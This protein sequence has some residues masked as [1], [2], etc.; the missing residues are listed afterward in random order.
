M[1]P[2]TASLQFA[3]RRGCPNESKTSLSSVGSASGCKCKPLHY[4]LPADE[5]YLYLFKTA[6]VT[7]ALTSE[8]CGLDWDNVDLLAGTVRIS[9]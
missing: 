6:V 7:G 4:T 2:R 1:S 3:H 8:L 5:V 9:E